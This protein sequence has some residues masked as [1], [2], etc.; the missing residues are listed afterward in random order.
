MIPNSLLSFQAQN[1]LKVIPLPNVPGVNGA[2]PNYVAAGTA[3]T[4]SD[5]FDVRVDRYQSEKIHMFG[6]YSLQQWGLSAPGAFGTEAGGA[7]FPGTSFL[8]KLAV[9]N[10]SLA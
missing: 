3:I 7:N 2:T 10:P 6:R 5:A 1:L 9:R 8:G 4:N